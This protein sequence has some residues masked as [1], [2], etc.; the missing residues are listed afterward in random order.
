M[1]RRHRAVKDQD[2]EDMQAADKT[3][4]SRNMERSAIKE[5]RDGHSCLIALIFRVLPGI[6]SNF[7]VSA[8]YYR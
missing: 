7:T 2:R 3:C 1:Y 8:H 5:T 4:D 6:V